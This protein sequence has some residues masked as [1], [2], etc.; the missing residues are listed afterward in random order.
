M[1]LHLYCRVSTTKQIEGLSL[2]I[3]G[4]E[5]VIEA[6]AKKY[7][8][9]VG[10]R[11]Y[12][13]EGKSAYKGMNLSGELGEFLNDIESGVVKAGD[14]LVCRALDRLSR[15]SLTNALN[16]YGR[17]MEAGVCIH[18]TMDDRRYEP[19]DQLSQILATLAFNTANEESE[20]KS[21]LTN[22]YA[23]TRI[24][25]FYAGKRSDDGY[26]FD[27]GVGK[28]PWY[29]TVVDKVVK[30]HLEKFQLARELVDLALDGK[31]IQTCR[32]YAKERGLNLSFTGMARFFKSEAL[33]GKL[34]VQLEDKGATCNHPTKEKQYVVRELDGYYPAV[35]TKAEFLRIQKIKQLHADTTTDRKYNV[36]ILAGFKRL[37]CQNG[38]SMIAATNKNVSYYRCGYADCQCGSYI[39]QYSLN[40]MILET[41]Q[42][43]VFMPTEQEDN[44]LLLDLEIE[45]EQ[46]TLEFKKR[47]RMVLNH[48]DLFDDEAMVKLAEDKA[49]LERVANELESAREE[50]AAKLSYAGGLSL[51]HFNEWLQKTEQYLDSTDED[52]IKEVR[53]RVKSV[54]RR[55]DYN[56]GLVKV[57]LADGS[58]TMLYQPQAKDRR[59]RSY[60]KLQIMNESMKAGSVSLNP[61]MQYVCFTE[62]EL[63]EQKHVI[64][65]EDYPTGLL[66]PC[67]KP[68]PVKDR[69][70]EF[71]DNVKAAGAVIWKRKQAMSVGIKDWQWQEYKDL[72]M[73]AEGFHVYEVQYKTKHYQKRNGQVVSVNAMSVDD[74]KQLLDSPKIDSFEPA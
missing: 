47:Q 6:L 62:S 72:D 45:L 60:L 24:E 73:K 40:R 17:I 18:T 4:D 44:H 25:Q 37:Y 31:G 27:I 48:P 63:L 9:T 42:H 64:K 43:H 13:D 51:E 29:F 7:N 56:S 35:C 2:S 30:P 41:L 36:S 15:L 21:Y 74:F 20:K 71:L 52:E 58:T 50:Q 65:A 11:V 23:L 16:V 53:E 12:R 54:V 10:Q 1:P 19:N 59:Q 61:A 33:Y 8:T 57:Q 55:I 34:V 28:H 49:E 38:Y 3:Q 69:K 26:S 39:P 46:K 66:K 68:L 22:K 67:S 32:K 70:A 14:I 5:S